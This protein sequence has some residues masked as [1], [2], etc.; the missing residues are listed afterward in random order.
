MVPWSSTLRGASSTGCSRP[1]AALPR[2]S[3]DS[4]QPAA[5]IGQISCPRYRLKLVSWPTVN[6]PRHTSQPP[7]PRVSTVAALSVKPTAGS[8]AASQRWASK[9][10]PDAAPA[11]AENCASLR[12]CRP[13]ARTVRTPVSVS[14]TWSFNALNASSER[15]H[16]WCTCPEIHQKPSAMNGKGNR[17]NRARRQSTPSDII[18]T[19]STSVWLPSKPASTASPAAISTASMSLVASAIRSPVRWPW[20]K[21]APCTDR[22]A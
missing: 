13:S 17:A 22:R 6:S 10:A 15:R 1:Q 12:A 7:T 11:S 9:L 8:Y 16:A 20:K 21:C 18:A 14:C 4:T 5:N 2:S 19:T 3:S